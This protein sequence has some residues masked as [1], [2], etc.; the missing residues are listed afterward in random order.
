MERRIPHDDGRTSI[1]IG[2]LSDSDDLKKFN[3]VQFIYIHIV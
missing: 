1:V 2:H 3:S